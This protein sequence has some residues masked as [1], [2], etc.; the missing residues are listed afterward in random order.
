M[1]KNK[2]LYINL[3][4]VL[5]LVPSFLFSQKA[6]IEGTVVDNSGNP[7][8]LANVS[9]KETNTGTT[10]DG[11]GH[12]R[13]EVPADRELTI[14]VSFVGFESSFKKIT[15][16]QGE[17]RTLDFSLKANATNLPDFEVR[18]ERLRTENLIRLNPKDTKVAPS[19]SN[20][21][22]SIIQTLPGVS[23]N[24]EMS[25]QYSVRGG[26][27][28][29][30]LVYV[31]GI[32]IYRPFLV[33]TGQQEGLS[34]VN[35]SLVSS[36]L[37]SSGGFG[38]RYGDK[39]SSVMDVKYIV[40][41]NFGGSFSASLLGADLSFHG[42][43]F[44]NRFTYLI[45]TRYKTN[46]YLLKS[47][48]TKGNY[49]PAFF[50]FQSLFTFQFNDKWDLSILGYYSRNRYKVVPTDRETDFG[51]IQAAFRF[52]VYFDG[53]E[54]DNYNIMQSAATLT[55][56]PNNFT[57][58]QF[59]ASGYSTDEA[60]SY[61][62]QGQ[63][64]IGLL[65]NN[66]KG[67]N[68]GEAV[69]TLGVGTYLHHARNRFYAEVI[70]LKHLGSYVDET[71]FLRWGLKYSRQNVD[72]RIR[73][74]DMIDS[75]GY[76]LPHPSNIPGDAHPSN[77]DF[78]LKNF[79]GGQNNLLINRYSAFISNEWKFKLKNR[80]KITLTGGLRA[81]YWDFGNEFLA[82]PRFN[83]SY[84]PHLKTNVVFRF[85]SGI[86]YQPPFYREMRNMD[87]TINRN[88]KSQ[89][90]IHFILGSDYRFRLWNSPFILTTELYYKKLDNLIPYEIDNVR[91]R[92]FADQTAK[93]YA[94]GI[95]FRLY[96]EFVKGIDSWISMSIMKTA[97]D[98]IGDYYYDYYNKNGEKIVSGITTDTEVAD[99]IRIEPGYI[100]RPTDRRV[101]FSIYFQDYIPKHPTYKVH[102]RL[103][104]GT[105][106]PFGAPNTQRYQQLLR[107]P[108]YRRVDIGFSKQ[109]I[110]KNSKFKAGN[111]L[112]NINQMWL[113][114][115][116]FNLFQVYNTVSYIW[117]SDVNNRQFAVP[118]YLTPRLL[119]LKLSIEF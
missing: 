4:F 84:K 116:V 100:P 34:F 31:N 24:N 57:N 88:I 36:V 51:T 65:E 75:A 16:K 30:N 53:A 21:I 114:L 1:I 61:D 33:S 14:G 99:G 101:N 58:L 106:F 71:H 117:V 78:I 25:S 55:F 5:I 93:G 87:G 118:N 11:K 67:N 102:L 105:G 32:E 8:E 35:P 60:E 110:G 54:I 104:Y 40:P 3:L 37:F 62:I 98:I 85:A 80:D 92:Y 59:I 83:L 69:Q 64:W 82:S 86:Y 7:V 38:A 66:P 43:A 89:R 39:M 49:K 94:A 20:G 19:I 115:E 97:E 113:S 26:N 2:I 112:K 27:F 74:W 68:Y 15:L 18:D 13:M 52:K 119:N 46:S 22:E 56:H 9:V 109:F 29:E 10:T 72:D 91:I 6:L 107:M 73:E 76:S 12:F 23:S 28:D 79:A 47:L 81:F 111:P 42:T 70:T 108:D 44:K 41:N 63:Y 103:I 45:G 48:D 96:G 50:D 90:S 95:D 77:P 17:K